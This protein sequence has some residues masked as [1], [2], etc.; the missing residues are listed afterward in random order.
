MR[1]GARSAAGTGLDGAAAL[2]T[3]RGSKPPRNPLVCYGQKKMNLWSAS[4]GHGPIS[5]YVC[6]RQTAIMRRLDSGFGEI[7]N[8]CDLCLKITPLRG[9]ATCATLHHVHQY[10][11]TLLQR[12]SQG[13]TTVLLQCPGL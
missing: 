4:K 3:H 7:M 1:F 5:L 8:A 9:I 6:Q 13:S 12:L 10:A 11:H 2:Q